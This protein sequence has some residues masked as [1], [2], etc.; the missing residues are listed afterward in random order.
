[1]QQFIYF[2]ICMYIYVYIYMYT[3]DRYMFADAFVRERESHYNILC[4][5][6]NLC[7]M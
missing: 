4:K 7:C 2:Y 5:Y 6:M 1:M 3:D